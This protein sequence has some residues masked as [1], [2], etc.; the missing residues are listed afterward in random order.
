MPWFN[1]KN[2]KVPPDAHSTLHTE[3]HNTLITPLEYI[4]PHTLYLLQ[5]TNCSVFACCN[6]QSPYIPQQGHISMNA[7]ETVINE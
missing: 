2:S 3:P 7:E 4:S 1:K 6:S 5:P